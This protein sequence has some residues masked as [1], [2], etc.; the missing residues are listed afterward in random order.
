M[1]EPHVAAPLS[2]P[3]FQSPYEAN[4]T[5]S[6]PLRLS[7]KPRAEFPCARASTAA[8]MAAVFPLPTVE[9]PPPPHPESN[10]LRSKLIHL[11][12]MLPDP[13]AAA[14]GHRSA[15]A[16][17]QARRRPLEHAEPPPRP[18]RAAPK[19][20]QGRSGTPLARPP[21]APRRRRPEPPETAGAALT[22]RSLVLKTG[23]GPFCEV[24]IL[25]GLPVQIP[26]THLQY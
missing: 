4:Y 5:F 23:Q 19:P 16:A 14:Q 2:L 7:P 10:Q 12:S 18:P 22:A 15:A 17:A 24:L 9:P 21:Q 13:L 8:A 3:P 26:G 20:P 25:S 6:S 11:P 1:S